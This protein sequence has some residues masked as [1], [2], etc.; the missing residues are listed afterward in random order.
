MTELGV[1]MLAAVPEAGNYF[2]T[3]KIL[4]MIVLM[5]PW[6]YASTWINK[7]AVTVHSNQAAW[8]LSAL[9]S[10]LVAMLLWLLLPWWLAGLGIYLVLTGSVIG[11][12]V[13]HRNKRVVPQARV[14]TAEHIKGL[15]GSRKS[16]V[17]E[18][19]RHVKL[20]SA[21]GRP[22]LAPPEEDIAARE[23]HNMAQN[24]LHNVILYRASDADLT[25][26]GAQAAVRFMVDGVIQQQPAAEREEAEAAID[27]MKGIAGL[28]VEEKRRPQSGKLSL[29]MGAVH[30]DIAVTTAGTTHGQ[31][32]QLR[33]V[34]EA[35]R[36]NLD[37][38]GLPEDVRKRVEAMNQVPKGLIIVS[39][40]R[41]NGLTSTLYSLLRR[42]DAFM[43]QLASM[44]NPR[45]VDLEN[46]S[47][48]TYKDQTELPKVLASMMRRDP[49]VMMV[50]R[51]ETAQGA[52]V[53][54]GAAAEKYLLLG[55][56]ADSS[57]VALA[58]WVKLA[59]DRKEEAL[60]VL[61]AILCQMLLRKLCPNCREAYHPAR[62]VLAKLNLPADKIEKLYRPPT[63]PLTD[64]KGNPI[65]C[66]TCHGTGYFGRTAAFELLELTD[67][68]RR[69]VLEGGSLSKIKAACRKGRMLYLQEQALRK[70]IE[71][72]TG[73]D[74][75][76][77]VSKSKQE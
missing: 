60:K 30:M 75:V 13:A 2:S 61:R 14:L 36:T 16:K 29:E 68:I 65:V 44:E 40:P 43:K 20:Y 38:L 7:D 56:N 27:Y 57:F 19:V 39:G 69:I 71:G 46:V 9:G 3:L 77:R 76:I 50:D 24:F 49:D 21:N 22:V 10:G 5:L 26:T 31:R 66:P 17:V 28:N 55:M 70:V 4:V 59:E 15:M 33:V 11:S 34:Q 42:H 45:A 12:Y 72:V 23:A 62:E 53:I 73:V 18:V 37:E 52:G 8:S 63:K 54:I 51:C 64:E 48:G 47:Q 6:L 41:Q 74:E 35:V 67:E 25:P 1:T 32:M 58:K